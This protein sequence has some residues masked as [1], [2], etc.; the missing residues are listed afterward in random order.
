MTTQLDMTQGGVWARKALCVLIAG[1]LAFPVGAQDLP[2][3]DQPSDNVGN[4]NNE[5]RA[6][7]IAPAEAAK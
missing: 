2:V 6:R 1:L 7:R 5:F 3:S 4:D